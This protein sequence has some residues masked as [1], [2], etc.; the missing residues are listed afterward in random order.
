[1]VYRLHQDGSFEAWGPGSEV[2]TNLATDQRVV[3]SFVAHLWVDADGR[4]STRSRC[5]VADCRYL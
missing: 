1:M 4:L 2:L 5:R 3:V